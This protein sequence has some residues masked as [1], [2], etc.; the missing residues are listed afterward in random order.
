MS[1]KISRIVAAVAAGL[2]AVVMLGVFLGGAGNAAPANGQ[3]TLTWYVRDNAVER[4]WEDQV[5]QAFR[6]THPTI[7]VELVVAPSWEGFDLRLNGMWLQGNPPDVWSPHGA[8]AFI[9]Y[10]QKGWLADLIPFINGSSPLTLTDFFTDSIAMYTIDGKVYGLPILGGGSFLFYNKELFDAAGVAYPPTDWDDPTWTWDAM[11]SKAIS[12]TQNPGDP[13]NAQYGVTTRLWPW[14]AYAWLWGQDLFPASAYQTGFASESFLDTPTATLA[15][16]ARQDLICT[17]HVSPSPDEEEALGGDAFRN[18]R[19]AMRMTG[20]WGLWDYK[21]VGFDWGFAALP[22]GTPGARDIVFTDPWLMSSASGH[23]D[24]AWEFLKFL[25]SQ[26][27]QRAHMQTT[28]APPVRRSLMPEWSTLFSATMTITQVQQVYAGALT[29]GAES[30]N[31][32]LAHYGKINDVLGELDP[33]GNNCSTSVT[34]T[35]ANAD[36]HLEQTL[37]WIIQT[38]TVPTV[39]LDINTGGVVTT[40]DGVATL[41]FDAR[42]V[43]E[44]TVVSVTSEE[45]I[46]E[47]PGLVS[48]GRV[49][50]M[51]ATVSD[52]GEV[53]TQTNTPYTMAVS[54]DE[55]SLG[56]LGVQSVA[57]ANQVREDTLALYWWNPVSRVWEREASSQVDTAANVVRATPVRFGLFAVFGK[58]QVYLPL[59]TRNH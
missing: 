37:A 30:P 3:V 18:Q 21:D 5:I 44:T 46:L 47:S 50:N 35:L 26:D 56:T 58:I 8:N 33:L 59:V 27:A 15:Y 53:L 9:D 17:H 20:A 34:D 51:V 43:S 55:G 40:N 22:K 45:A 49:V 54:Y 41:V 31:H 24:E 10:Y 19:A 6:P 11:V 36:T 32:M 16:Q 28:N 23:P 29:H 48:A 25:V 52:T 13:D 2:F 7:T 1:N 39:T 38:N 4:Q 42:T 57:E 12:L 14:D